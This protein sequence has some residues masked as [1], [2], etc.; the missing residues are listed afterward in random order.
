MKKG[1]KWAKTPRQRGKKKIARNTE[2]R[3]SKN[4]SAPLSLA[5]TKLM[6]RIQPWFNAPTAELRFGQG[7]EK[8]MAKKSYVNLAGMRT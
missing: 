4:P 1:G 3:R 5:R 8:K 2:K 7:R 6:L